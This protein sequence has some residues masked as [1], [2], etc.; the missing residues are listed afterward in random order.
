MSRHP[1]LDRFAL[2]AAVGATA[3]LGVLSVVGGSGD[4]FVWLPE[5]AVG[6]AWLTAALLAPS[7]A[8]WFA[9]LAVVAAATWWLAALVPAAV[10]W[11]RALIVHAVLAMPGWMPRSLLSRI[12]VVACY[13][14]S[15]LVWPWQEPGFAVA[16]ALAVLA[17][18][19]SR[20]RVAP[21]RRR[22]AASAVIVAAFV[23]PAILLSWGA[24]RESA[25]AVWWAYTIALITVAVLC[26]SEARSHSRRAVTDLVV[27]LGAQPR[28]ELE[29]ALAPSRLDPTLRADLDAAIAAAEAL[30]E[31]HA[32]LRSELTRTLDDVSESHR[33]LLSAETDARTAL[34]G[35]LETGSIARIRRLLEQLATESD[36]SADGVHAKRAAEH[37]RGALDDVTALVHGLTPPALGRGLCEALAGLADAVPLPVAVALPD[38]RLPSDI[39]TCVFLITAEALSNVGKHARASSASVRLTVDASNVSLEIVDD[40][41]GGADTNAGDGLSGIRTRAATMRGRATVISP[42]GRGT[43]VTVTLP[44]DGSLVDEPA[45]RVSE[46]AP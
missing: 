27:E 30:V 26:A 31:Q 4:A 33:R 12:V 34:Q 9:V 22:I 29:R 45:D 46:A 19:V 16:L 7:G 1:L 40:G 36:A 5:F 11:H 38:V 20:Q 2:P 37:L 23:L 35:E 3:V 6:V 15:I 8:R 24:G 42:P 14:A 39:E 17:A 44:L 43:T 25:L 18:T 41:V 32:R 10:F 28:S 13:L 21:S